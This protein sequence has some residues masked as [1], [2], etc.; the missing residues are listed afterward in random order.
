M[1]R[2]AVLRRLKGKNLPAIVVIAALPVVTL[3]V[4]LSGLALAAR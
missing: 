2:I 3:L 4:A 1:S